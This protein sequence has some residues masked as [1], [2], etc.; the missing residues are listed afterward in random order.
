MKA[1]RMKP[2][3]SEHWAQNVQGH[4]RGLPKPGSMSEAA[5]IEVAEDEP[6]V[7]EG[8]LELSFWIQMMTWMKIT[9]FPLR[10]HGFELAHESVFQV[11][12]RR[13]T[14]WLMLS[15]GVKSFTT[16]LQLVGS[17]RS[18]ETEC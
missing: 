3:S 8:L 16:G 4:I 11:T 10:P 2:S 17:R 18:C 7:D 9:N 6:G 12:S 14:P 1:S 15:L 5:P 13:T